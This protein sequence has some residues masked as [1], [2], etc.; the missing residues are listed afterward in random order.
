MS[1]HVIGYTEAR[2][3]GKWYCIDYFQYDMAGRVR[4]IPCIDGQS[5][6]YSALD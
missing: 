2:I 1:R 4:H 3:D 5:L 6:V